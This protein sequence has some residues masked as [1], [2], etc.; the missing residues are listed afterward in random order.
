[1]Y[2]ILSGFWQH[3]MFDFT[4][5]LSTRYHR[6]QEWLDFGEGEDF[7]ERERERERSGIL[8]FTHWICD[9]ICRSS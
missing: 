4:T 6:S 7:G 5:P 3:N 8:E 1:M 9:S 2:V